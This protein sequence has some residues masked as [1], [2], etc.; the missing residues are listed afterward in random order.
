[1]AGFTTGQNAL[2]TQQLANI[3]AEYTAD[4][5]DLARAQRMAEMLTSTQAP[6]GQMISGRYVAPSWTQSLAQLANAGVGAYFGNQAEEKQKKLAEQ[7]RQDK[8]MTQEGIMSAI[9]KGDMKKALAIA[10]TRPEYGKEFIAP[11]LGNVI[12]KPTELKQNYQD[13]L[14]SGGK[15]TIL[16]YQRYAANLKQEHPSYTPFESNGLMYVMNS[17]TGQPQPMLDASGKQLAAKSAE[18]QKFKDTRYTLNQLGDATKDYLNDLKNTDVRTLNP[19]SQ[20][21]ADLQTKFTNV[22]MQVKGLYELGAITGPDLKLLNQAITNPNSIM[23]RVRGGQTLESQVKVMDDI[24][25]RSEKNLYKT[26]NL[27]IP[28]NLQDATPPANKP[29]E[30]PASKGPMTFS[31]EADAAKAKL[32]DGTPVI[33]NGVSGT[34]KN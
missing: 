27:P 7:L 24:I 34:W 33:I 17:R 4:A 2:T 9:D 5:Q 32:K 10:S 23:G 29:N 13:W 1:M 6:E 28:E 3:P 11:L 19:L 25:R 14:A 22:Q 30:P 15:G 20:K 12:P 18:P 26:Y 21:A 31:S 8:M 16:D